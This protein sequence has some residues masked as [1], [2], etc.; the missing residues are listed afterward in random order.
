VGFYCQLPILRGPCWFQ[1]RQWFHFHLH[2]KPRRFAWVLPSLEV[3]VCPSSWRNL[4]WRWPW[5][6]WWVW[7][8]CW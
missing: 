8:G 4:A 7:W 5:R 1:R 3:K 2:R 6:R